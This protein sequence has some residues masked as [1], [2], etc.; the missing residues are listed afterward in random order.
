MIGGEREWRECAGAQE[1]TRR[2][3]RGQDREKTGGREEE[4]R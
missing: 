1:R 3:R 2:D 4:V